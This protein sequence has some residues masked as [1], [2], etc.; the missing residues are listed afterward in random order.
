MRGMNEHPSSETDFQAA[1]PPPIVRAG[2]GAVLGAG[3]LVL[4]I[5]VQ[6]FTGFTLSTKATAS[7]LV[8]TL[9]GLASAVAGLMLMRARA[10]PR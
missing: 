1:Q 4:L 6:T 8:V 7:L 5:A 10:A 2:G 3:A 9:L